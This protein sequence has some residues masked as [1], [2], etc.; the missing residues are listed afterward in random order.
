MTGYRVRVIDAELDELLADLAAVSLEG[1]KGV[2]KTATAERRGSTVIRLDDPAIVEVVR[3]QP[4]RLTTGTPPVVI[5]EW[6]R[7]PESWDLV[8][9]AVDADHSAGR[10]ILTGSA[11]PIEPPTHSGAGRIAPI[12][13]R[14]LSLH[15]RG[16]GVPTVSLAELL[17]RIGS[18]EGTTEIGLEDYVAETVAGGFPGMRHRSPRAQRTALDGYLAR[19]ID[20]DLP[21]L[22][23]GIRKPSTLRRWLAAYAAA[24]ATTTSYDRIR[25]AATPAEDEKPAKTT[26][27][28]YRDALERI[29]V[30]DPVPAWSPTS[31]H[32]SRLTASPKHHLADPALAA[33]LVG[34]DA[35]TLL[36]GQGPDLVP[37]DGTFLGQLFES[38]VAL[39]VRVFAQAAEATVSH[40]RD[41]NG[42]HEVDFIVGRNH[43]QVL[44]IEV[45]LSATVDDRDVRHLLWLREQ[46][47]ESLVDMVI[48]TTG[49]DAYRRPDGVAVVPLALLGP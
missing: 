25:N 14:P 24:T 16:V 13:M 4:G 39:S 37:H 6:Q 47:G 33:R 7:F 49:A 26:T 48:V 17:G 3:A 43:Q 35:R 38:L 31:N 1:P 28:G 9:R 18:V 11:T 20:T 45:K 44:G 23:V 34:A 5:D 42:R 46:L 27:I 40:Y 36:A 2:G 41:R 8:R 22:G 19:I 30:L 21:E 29:W 32:L 12:R 15:E 10:F